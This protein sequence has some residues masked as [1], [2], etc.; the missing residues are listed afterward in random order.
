MSTWFEALWGFLNK[1]NPPPAQ[2]PLAKPG[3]HTVSPPTAPRVDGILVPRPYG[4]RLMD[5][6]K[7]RGYPWFPDQNVISHEGHN[8]D[9]TRNANRDNAFDDVKLILDGNGTIIGGPWRGTTQP[10]EYWTKHPMASGGAFIIALGPQSVWTPG[11]YHNKTVWRQAEDS[12]IMGHR[13]PHCTFKRVGPPV[14]HGNIGVHHH[15]GYNLP[16]D[17]ISN[18]AAGCQVIEYEDGQA[19]FMEK[20]LKCPRYLS[21]KHGYRLTAIVFGHDEV[22]EV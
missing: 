5:E 18:A 14:A 22:P 13:D 8:Q 1:A 9:G 11:L 12:T 7:K 17:N 20:T 4:I 16:R 10:G 2:S 6:C 19:D 21:D 15:G 3:P